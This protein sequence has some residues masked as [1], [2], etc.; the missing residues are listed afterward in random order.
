MSEGIREI[1]KLL[2]LLAETRKSFEEA[3]A[4]VLD[5]IG[6]DPRRLALHLLYDLDR[7]P[8]PGIEEL[9]EAIRRSMRLEEGEDVAAY[10]RR[11]LGRVESGG[12]S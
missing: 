11:F 3:M 1:V 12:E 5:A 6:I 7:G 2:A 4:S 8:Q 10:L 9:V